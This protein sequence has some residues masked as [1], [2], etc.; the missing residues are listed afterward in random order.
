MKSSTLI[1]VIVA[2]MAD[3]CLCELCVGIQNEA[4]TFGFKPLFFMSEGKE[5]LE[6]EALEVFCS[7]Q[8]GTHRR[9]PDWQAS[10]DAQSRG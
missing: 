6:A 10:L 4:R 7:E 1:G 2:V 5:D 8:E 3:G 9:F